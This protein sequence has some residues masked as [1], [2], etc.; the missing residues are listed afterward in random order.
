MTEHAETTK[1]VIDALSIITVIGT[2]ADMLPSVAAIFTIV[3][4][5]IRIWETATVQS[6]VKKLRG[7]DAI[8]QP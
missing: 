5:S 3:W 2:L 1:S 6:W 8:D 7:K 4:T